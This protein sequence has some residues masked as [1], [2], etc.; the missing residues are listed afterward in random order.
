MDWTYNCVDSLG[1]ND[2]FTQMQRRQFLK[3]VAIAGATSSFLNVNSFAQSRDPK[4]KMT[5]NLVCGAIGVKAD[6][7]RA[8]ELASKFGFESVEAKADYLASLSDGEVDA[9]ERLLK[10]RKLVWGTSGLSVDFRGDER[11]FKEG[12]KQLPRLAKGLQ[13]AGVERVSTWLRPAHHDLTYNQNFKQH[14]DRLRQVCRILKDNDIRFGMEYVGTNTLLVSR[15]YPFIHSMA[16]TRELVDAIGTGNAG[17][18]LDSWHWWQAGDSV[19]DI[20]K[21]RNKDIILVDL[22]DA[23]KDIDKKRQL[24]GQ[25]QLPMATG[26]IDTEGFVKALVE[27]GYDGPIRAEPFNQTLRDLDDESACKATI[28]SL[29]KAIALVS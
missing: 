16:E 29:R 2:S 3:A 18:V 15:K 4:R 10:D 11:K 14:A 26:V 24:D 6:Q 23:P 8:I 1:R 21:L 19:S 13:R 7:K 28:G 17:I 9:L 12:L 5:L 20:E 25:R 22:N 27:I